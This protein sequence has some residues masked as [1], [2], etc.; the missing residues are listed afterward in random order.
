LAVNLTYIDVY[1]YFRLSGMDDIIT[2]KVQVQYMEC[3]VL[4][5]IQKLQESHTHS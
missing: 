1:K 2:Y 4:T 5:Q 3:T